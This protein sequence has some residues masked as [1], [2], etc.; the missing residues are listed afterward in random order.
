MKLQDFI[1]MIIATGF[2]IF[3]MLSFSYHLNSFYGVT[4]DGNYSNI[5]DEINTSVSEGYEIGNS[6]QESVEG[7][8][9]SGFIGDLTSFSS[10]IYRALKIPFDAIKIQ[11]EIFTS[12][13]KVIPFPPWVINGI[14][15]LIVISITFLI[16]GAVLRHNV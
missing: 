6:I 2:I 13:F 16:L 5:Y 7:S 8:E 10:G 14:I 1:V 11:T 3:G 4:V 12:F 9:R 15:I